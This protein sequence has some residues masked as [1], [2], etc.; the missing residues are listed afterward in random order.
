[1]LSF[2]SLL[3]IDVNYKYKNNKNDKIGYNL[4]KNT[5]KTKRNREIIIK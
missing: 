4:L 1:M 3:A 5:K 2:I